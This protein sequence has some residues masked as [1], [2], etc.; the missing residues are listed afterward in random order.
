MDSCLIWSKTGVPGSSVETFSP[1]MYPLLLLASEVDST[2]GSEMVNS[3]LG[4]PFKGANV[5]NSSKIY[6]ELT[7]AGPRVSLPPERRPYLSVRKFRNEAGSTKRAIYHGSAA[8]IVVTEIRAE[9]C[10]FS[11]IIRDVRTQVTSEK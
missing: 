8:R 4:L 10:C 3:N 7:P 2:R 6:S 11:N 5:A 1:P 9:Q